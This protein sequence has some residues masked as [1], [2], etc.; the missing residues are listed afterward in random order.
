MYKTKQ[1]GGLSCK[2]IVTLSVVRQSVN[3]LVSIQEHEAK[4]DLIHIIIITYSPAF[5]QNIQE[6][7][8]NAIYS[9]QE[10]EALIARIDYML[11]KTNFSPKQ[12]ICL[13]LVYL[14]SAA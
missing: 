10:K 11:G 3:S 9:K 5:L 4:F 14:Q 7:N 6:I 13:M 2:E 8:S 12:L 1:T